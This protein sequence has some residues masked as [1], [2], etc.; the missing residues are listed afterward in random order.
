MLKLTAFLAG[1]AAFAAITSSPGAQAAS[2][3]GNFTADDYATVYLSTDLVADDSEIV[4]DKVTLWG[5]TQSFSGIALTPGQNYYLLVLARNVFSG[6]AMF[7][8]DFSISGEGFR[9]SNGGQTL[10]TDTTDWTVNE[11]GFSNA[12]NTP[13]SLGSNGPSL[14]IWGGRPGISA[15]AEAVWAY[16]ADW[17]NGYN[18]PAY[19]VAQITAVP[20]PASLAMFGAGLAVLG[21]VARRRRG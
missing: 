7:V 20:E 5:S 15:D 4:S 12:G 1:A 11:T 17:S 14:Q 10:L 21:A 3:S 16:Y 13:V 19:F 2:L 18:G 9:F 6:P 8:G